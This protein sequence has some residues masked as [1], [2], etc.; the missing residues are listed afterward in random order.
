MGAYQGVLRRVLLSYKERGRRSLAEPL[1]VLLAAAIAR[2]VD[3]GTVVLVPVPATAAAVR[4]RRG[5]HM[6]RLARVARATLARA[7][8]PAVVWRALRARP[9]PDS[10]GL[11]AA[12]RVAVA[13]AALRPR[14]WVRRRPTRDGRV[15]LVDDVL[16]TGAT[17]VAAV[18]VLAERGLRVH[19]VVVLAAT[20]RRS[21][22]RS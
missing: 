1:G 2:S 19:R 10:T 18:R 3:A 9:R 16:T 7:G 5:D 20:R 4:R 22:Y 8:V 6:L 11:T 14:H 13:E 17:A 12:Q 21:G 15:V